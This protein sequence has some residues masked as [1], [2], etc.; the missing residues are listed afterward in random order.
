MFADDVGWYGKVRTVP[1]L[2]SDQPTNANPDRVGAVG[3]AT[4]SPVPKLPFATAEPELE[5][6]VTV[7]SCSHLAKSA[8]PAIA[9]VVGFARRVPFE[10]LDHPRNL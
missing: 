7:E 10:V 1:L 4:V 9:E 8:L 5:L 3:A 2:D 6:N